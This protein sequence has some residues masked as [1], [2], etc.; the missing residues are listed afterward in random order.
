M[1]VCV[2]NSEENNTPS[3]EIYS[4]FKEEVPKHLDQHMPMPAWPTS[5]MEPST[6]AS[7]FKSKLWE[8]TIRWDFG[9]DVGML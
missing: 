3:T 7:F 8:I 6:C 1:V 5:Y 9:G 2:Y 4:M